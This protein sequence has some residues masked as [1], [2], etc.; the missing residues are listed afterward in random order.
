MVAFRLAGVNVFAD[1]QGGL[2]WPGERILVLADLHLEKGASIARRTSQMLPPYDTFA[3]LSVMQQ[4]IDRHDPRCV[5]CLGDSFH[6]AEGAMLLDA[7]ARA[8]LQ[9]LM[10]RRRFVW[11]EGNH[12]AA[13]AAV[14]GGEAVAAL[15]VGPLVFRHEP[16]SDGT[17]PGEVA[18]H[19][20]PA[21]RVATRARHVRRKCFITNGTR[22]IL[23]SLGA[24]T[25]GLDIEDVV[26]E[27]LFSGAYCAYALGRGRVYPFPTPDFVARGGYPGLVTARTAIPD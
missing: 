11:I 8:S 1:H 24:F 16:E 26:F 20:H 5:V 3:T 19:L 25:G 13:A 2:W 6:D 27:R 9:G 4:I 14:L 23:P 10:R 7:R 18:G 22:C 15:S 17:A 12:D 21:V